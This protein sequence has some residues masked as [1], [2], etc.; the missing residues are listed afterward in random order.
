[1]IKIKIGNLEKEQKKEEEQEKKSS[2][3]T[4]MQ[5][6]KSLDGKL[7]ITDHE[8]L[9]IVIDQDNSK[10]IAFSTDMKNS[11]KTY[12]TQD[13]FFKYLI[14]KGVI[15]GPSV[16]AGN[17]YGCLEGQILPSSDENVN[18]IDV[19]LLV[20]DRW[21]DEERPAFVYLKQKEEE[22]EKGLTEPKE[23]ETT[24]LGKIKPKDIVE[25]F[26]KVGSPLLP[27]QVPY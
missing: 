16:K 9:D 18:N 3:K 1:M 26:G 19:S 6:R 20:I 15:D 8:D 23:D 27:T 24:R 22:F 5:I 14:K 2:L 4:N 17:I 7:I 25:P 21:I 10:I 13:R 11:D 12:F